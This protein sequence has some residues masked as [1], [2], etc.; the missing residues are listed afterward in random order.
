MCQTMDGKSVVTR[1]EEEVWTAI[2]PKTI[3]AWNRLAFAESPSLT[4]FRSNFLL[5]Y[6][7]SLPH[8]TLEGSCGIIKHKQNKNHQ[9]VFPCL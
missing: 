2:P 3:S 1:Q 5:N 8:N 7:A 4:V 6:R 9:K